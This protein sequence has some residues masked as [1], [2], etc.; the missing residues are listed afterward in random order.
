MAGDFSGTVV[1]YMFFTIFDKEKQIYGVLRHLW[2]SKLR[3]TTDNK[4]H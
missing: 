4:Y 2:D 1:Y 3:E